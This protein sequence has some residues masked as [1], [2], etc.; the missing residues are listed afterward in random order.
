MAE[1]FMLNPWKV[2]HSHEDIFI[3][4]YDRLMGWTLRL[5][6][7]QEKAE[8]LLH[9]A[10]IHFTLARPDLGSIQNLEGYLYAVVRNLHLSQVRRDARHSIT[11]LSLI[12]FDSAEMGL[13]STDPRA[14]SQV[15]DE[16]CNI[17]H[18]ACI[19]KVTSKAGSVL[20][21]RFFHGYFP[22]EIALLLR[23]PRRAVDDWMRIARREVK[24][25]IENPG[26]LS[27]ARPSPAVALLEAISGQTSTEFLASLRRAIFAA[28][29]DGCPT[30]EHWQQV[31]GSDESDSL[32]SSLL[33][34]LVSCPR[35]LD[36]VN[37]L[38]G[39][40][41]LSD[42][43][44]TDM[45][46]PDDRS[47][48]SRPPS[49]PGSLHRRQK[50]VLEHFPSELYLSV[51][52][53]MLGSQKI[54]SDVNEQTLSVNVSEKIGFV[55]ILSEQGVRLLFLNVEPPPDGEADQSA[56]VELSEGRS[57][58]VNLSFSESWPKAQTVYC[59]PSLSAVSGQWSVVSDQSIEAINEPEAAPFVREESAPV[60]P[61]PG[62]RMR[63]AFAGFRL[64]M[65]PGAVTALL[66]IALIALVVYWRVTPPSVSATELLQRARD[67]EDAALQKPDQA[68]HRAFNLEERHASQL[69]SRRRV[70]VWAN[71]TKGTKARRVYTEKGQM[72]AAEWIASDGARTIFR[73]G[74]G[75]EIS[76][77][78]SGDALNELWRLDPSAKSFAAI[79]PNIEETRVEH[80]PNAY[81]I[82]Y[83]P[84]DASGKLLSAALR[85]RKAD[86]RAVEQILQLR[87]QEGVY[88]YRLV[89]SS[90]ER[91]RL[92][93]IAPRV[94]EPDREI[95]SAYRPAVIRRE[96]VEAR[97]PETKESAPM[98]AA[99]LLGLEAE[100]L[101][102]LH[103]IGGCLR[104]QTEVK[105][106]D[107]GLGIQAIVDSEKRRDEFLN[108]L[109]SLSST[110]GVSLEILTAAEAI[111]QQMSL[112]E[113]PAVARRVE[114]RKDRMPVY[115]HL[116]SHFAARGETDE[117]IQRFAARMMNHSRRALLHTWALKQIAARFSSAE[118]SMLDAGAQA[119][120]RRIAA[121]HAL[122]FEQESGALAEGLYP[123]F[124]QTTEQNSIAD[125]LSV[126]ETA[127]RIFEA[128]LFH[129]KVVR[130]AFT[131][132]SDGAQSF[133]ISAR[134]FWDSLAAARRM[135]RGIQNEK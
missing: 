43:Y 64:L 36:E 83:Q 13:R 129:E 33:S 27:I 95:M 127:E 101:Y 9:D 32:D 132:S 103:S 134:Q 55:E 40:P 49:A 29:H 67:R 79:I 109:R 10:F 88:E 14:E 35:C 110:A 51:N 111:S 90:F 125:S 133:L 16:L 41:P 34:H 19:R 98:G 106:T 1:A 128:A 3:E 123:V 5:T 86:L 31:Y 28:K 65:R 7:N 84:A 47:K 18:Y 75:V 59:D 71:T 108:A 131:V 11:Q 77:K 91:H 23:S 104:E 116:R 45:L 60:R 102:Q 85:I 22:S 66:A 94:F 122:S 12:D 130:Q 113:R 8:D 25:H 82:N 6:Q 72:I 74:V 80:E 81:V 69:I 62:E 21:L 24:L 15:R 30:V 56:R 2:A 26:R 96:A 120:V 57:L 135:A 54:G 52:G 93:E 124:G 87:R 4:R 17:C 50:E 105:R 44:P 48:R 42:R 46:G 119:R 58:E 63:R 73:L 92:S 20:I 118:M 100:A 70:E 38:L 76:N 115:E 112:P 117:E 99:A 97:A 121:D 61:T 37:R 78:V 126:S 114:I 107:G 39:L 89:E 53:F 68:V